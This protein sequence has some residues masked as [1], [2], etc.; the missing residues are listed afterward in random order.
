MSGEI[1][2]GNQDL[3]VEDEAI[4]RLLA[5]LDE[6][7][8]YMRGDHSQLAS[9]LSDVVSGWRGSAASQFSTGQNEMNLTLDRLIQALA[10]LRELVQMSRQGFEAEEQERAA[11]LRNVQ[12][13]VEELN[14]NIVG[15]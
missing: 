9:M 12:S 15:A 14:P 11:E 2:D 7:V 13:G 4:S 10:N 1:P 6:T 3:R 8:E 5:K